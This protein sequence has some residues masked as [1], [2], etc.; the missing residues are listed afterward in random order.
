MATIK[1]DK[2]LP[3]YRDMLRIR[4]FEGKATKLYE[5]GV[6]PGF[7]HSSV[8]QEAVPVGV[9]AHLNKD[10]YITSNH[11]GHG[12]VLAKGM[13]PVRMFAEL[14]ARTTGYNRGRGGSMHIMDFSLGIVGANGIV[15]A[16]VPIAAGAGLSFQV[17]QTQQV[18]VSYFGDGA[19]NSGAFHE[20]MNLAAIWSLPVVFVCENNFYAESVPQAY[21]S[22]VGIAERAAAYGIP[23]VMVDGND[24]FAVYDAAKTA[25][26]R[27]RAGEGP[28]LLECQT[29]RWSGHFVGDPGVYRSK[30]E[31]EE[32]KLKDPV[33]RVR[34]WLESHGVKA[35][36][37]DALEAEV[38]QEMDSAAERGAEGPKPDPSTATQDVYAPEGVAQA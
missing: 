22:R 17:R 38:V 30:E 25:I 20:G 10:D 1:A 7:L 21:A 23:G 5:Q 13:D 16:G 35:G 2:V 33:P 4:G 9:S 6:L 37:L 24:L 3:L 12:H 32:W 31:V 27:A 11:R 14:Y 28:T 19:V 8:G 15:G 34:T 36:E 29:F 26:E 18:A